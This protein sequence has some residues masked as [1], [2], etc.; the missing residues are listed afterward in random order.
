[1][2][3][4]IGVLFLLMVVVGSVHSQKKFKEDFNSLIK[5]NDLAKIEILLKDWE[6]SYPNDIELQI[7]YFNFFIRKSTKSKVSMGQRGNGEYAIYEHKNYDNIF[8]I[9]AIDALD[10]ALKINP[11]RLDVH[12]GKCSF[13][14][15]KSVL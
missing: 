10:K 3:K 8:Y 7:A 4:G 14:K 6:K 2:K 1:M 15:K 12:F 11:N 5:K 9:K 13:L